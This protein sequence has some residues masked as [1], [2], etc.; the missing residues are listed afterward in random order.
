MQL[1]VAV[2]ML[3]IYFLT[4]TE[5]CV[6]FQCIK[7]KIAQYSSHCVGVGVTRAFHAKL[8]ASMR[9]NEALG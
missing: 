7:Y 1:S 6:F 3:H 2:H 4:L 5:N 8:M 9:A